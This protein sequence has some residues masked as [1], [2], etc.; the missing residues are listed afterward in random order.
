MVQEGVSVA[1]S[2]FVVLVVAV[3]LGCVPSWAQQKDQWVPGQMGLNAG[4]LPDPGF[5]YLNMTINYSAGQ[6]ND[7]TSTPLPG[8]TGDYSFWAIE[9]MFMWVFDK[10]ILGAHYAPYTM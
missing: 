7:S 2:R 1:F 4:V 8:L 10:K 9:N 5:T 3:V 6:L